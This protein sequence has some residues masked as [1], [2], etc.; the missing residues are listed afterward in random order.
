MEDVTRQL[1]QLRGDIEENVGSRIASSKDFEWLAA[2]INDRLHE[3]VS[4]STLKRVWGYVNTDSTPRLSTLNLL[5]RFVGYADWQDYCDHR[6]E[7]DAD[8]VSA[9]AQKGADAG[10]ATGDTTANEPT[11]MQGRRAHARAWVFGVVLTAAVLLLMV[12]A[13]QHSSS[14]AAGDLVLKKGQ[15][16]GQP[17]DYLALF[18]ITDSDHCW[19][20]P[21]TDHPSLVVWTPRYQHPHWHNEGSRDSLF[22]TITEYWQPTETGADTIEP[23][24]VKVKNENLFFTVTRTNEL[25]IT[26][27]QG[28]A[29]GD[30]CTFLGV[31][32]V[33][34]DRSDSTHVVWQRIAEEIDLCEL[35]RLEEL[36]N[37]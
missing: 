34:L 32:R 21:L 37:R 14:S 31:Y 4:V 8:S 5:A 24:L 15:T 23:A 1:Q 20:E 33:D 30:S 7:E 29:G 17:A 2:T 16:F 10:N 25:R 13:W 27:M 22:P 36:R 11:H 26:F 3:R 19:D 18:G 12:L 28:I 9:S 35:D 6:R